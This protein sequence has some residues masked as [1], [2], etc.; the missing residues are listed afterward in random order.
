MMRIG[1][2]V[3]ITDGASAPAAAAPSLPPLA[4][5]TALGTFA[6]G[7]G[8][9]VP[10]PFSVG[11]YTLAA[12]ETL[13]VWTTMQGA[14]REMVE[15]EVVFNGHNMHRIQGYFS[16]LTI[17]ESLWYYKSAA[18]ETGSLAIDPLTGAGSPSLFGLVSKVPGLADSPEDAPTTLTKA[19]AT[20]TAPTIGPSAAAAQAAELVCA[21]FTTVGNV[22]DTRGTWGNSLTAGQR[23]GTHS[24]DGTACTLDEAYRIDAVT[25]GKTASKTGQTSRAYKAN[26]FTLKGA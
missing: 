1:I 17:C 21:M 12:G 11:P 4:L 24:G 18:G 25:T 6:Y 10:D 22:T 23:D 2:G 5:P 15:G 20:T 13:L 26:L 8:V 19:A 7:D 16:N 14:N 3:A 9:G